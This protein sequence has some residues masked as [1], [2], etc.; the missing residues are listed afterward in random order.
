M[1]RFFVLWS[2]IF[3]LFFGC[4][5]ASQKISNKE[6]AKDLSWLMISR[7]SI[8]SLS[9]TGR[10]YKAFSKQYLENLEWFFKKYSTPLHVLAL[11]PTVDRALSY[12]LRIQQYSLSCE[13]AALQI[14]LNRLWI[15]V[16]EDDIFLSIQKYSFPYSSGWIWWDPDMEFVW[17]YNGKQQT[18]TGYGVYAPPLAKYAQIYSLKTEILDQ[19]NYDYRYTS[20]SHMEY[21]LQLLSDKDSHILLWWDYCTDPVFEDGVMNAGWKKLIFEF[22]PLPARNNCTMPYEKRIIS[23]VTPEGK[24]IVWLSWEHA[25]VLLG[26][27]WTTKNPTHII[28]WDTFTGRHVYPY[29]EWMRK[30]STMQ[31]RSL[32]ISRKK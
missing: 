28:V 9:G 7:A 14:I 23:W 5:N 32:I 30:W 10:T 11:R 17:L 13:I 18:T 20:E 26:Y 29:S 2:A 1:F 12:R 8:E 15:G 3:F 6:L 19:S 25:F 21:L 4:V 22:F 16:N 31:N 27:V 24:E